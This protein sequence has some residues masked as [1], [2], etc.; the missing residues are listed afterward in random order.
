MTGRRGG[1][2]SRTARREG[3]I[4][5]P[6][7]D[8]MRRASPG[9]AGVDLGQIIDP[10]ARYHV[11]PGCRGPMVGRLEDGAELWRCWANPPCGSTERPVGAAPLRP[12]APRT[13]RRP[14]RPARPAKRSAV[15]TGRDAWRAY[16]PVV[17]LRP[18]PA[19]T[20][21]RPAIPWKI[22][23]AVLAIIVA[24]WLVSNPS[25]RPSGRSD[26]PYNGG[27]QYN[28]Y[29]VTCRDGWISHSGGIQG[30]CSGH[31]GVRR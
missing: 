13:T 8:R 31:G 21:R 24:G 18:V 12:P 28:G 9:H 29:V 14:R 30:A 3:S 5:P 7:C 10:V 27:P 23:T 11:C 20:R 2:V 15:P 17:P 6:R 25:D 19:P 4:V 16:E 26:G 22:V 1:S